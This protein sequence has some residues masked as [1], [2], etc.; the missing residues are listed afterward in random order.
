MCP[1]PGRRS[2]DSDG[3]VGNKTDRKRQT[4][5]WQLTVS[6]GD[7][8]HNMPLVLLMKLAINTNENKVFKAIFRE[9][10]LMT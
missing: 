2:S 3:Y 8:I 1:F 6:C 10:I 4:R 9:I 5:R 7:F